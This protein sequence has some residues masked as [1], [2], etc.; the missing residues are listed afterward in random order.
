MKHNPGSGRILKQRVLARQP[1]VCIFQV[2][3][4]THTTSMTTDGVQ[5]FIVRWCTREHETPSW[6]VS[7]A[8][9]EL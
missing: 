7:G 3:W 2:C 9:N 4:M 8:T 1:R 6:P 5:A